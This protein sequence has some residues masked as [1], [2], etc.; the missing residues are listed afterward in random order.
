MR[1][2]GATWVVALGWFVSAERGPPPLQDLGTKPVLCTPSGSEHRVIHKDKH[3]PPR[4]VAMMGADAAAPDHAATAMGIP[5][6]PRQRGR[7]RSPPAGICTPRPEPLGAS[8]GD[9]RCRPPRHV[10]PGGGDGRAHLGL[11]SQSRNR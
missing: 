1:W 4:K 6:P 11:C 8:A 3:A 5:I 10:A 9:R 2:R 7:E